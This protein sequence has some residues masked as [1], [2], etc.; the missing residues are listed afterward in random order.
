MRL[1]LVRH[2]QTPCNLIDTWHG[3]D[4]CGLTK[5]GKKQAEAAARRLASEP[6]AAVH[7]SDSRRAMETA[8]AIGRPHKL[9]PVASRA[10]RE[11]FA[12]EFEGLSTERVV[13]LRPTVWDERAADYWGWSPPGG[14]TFSQVLDRT[15]AGVESLRKA[16]PD[17][18]VALVG[19]MGTVRVLVAH[20][21]GISLEQTYEM[22]FPSTGVSIFRFDGDDVQVET[23]NNGA[24]VA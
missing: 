5:L 15:L 23:L 16:H 12:G 3:W 24:H 21:L 18:T 9:T 11:R 22:E 20:F 17:R 13:A 19:H 8:T 1:I 14:E 2:G 10:F 4:D 6:L 7:S